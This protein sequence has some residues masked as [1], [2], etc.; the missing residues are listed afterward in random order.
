MPVSALASGEIGEHVDDLKAN[1][2]DYE[3]EVTWFNSKVDGLVDTY[4]DK[5]ADAVDTAEP[6]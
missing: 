2:G 6:Y 1:L 5:G 4:A 3:E